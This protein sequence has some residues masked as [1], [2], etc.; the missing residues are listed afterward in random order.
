MTFRG[1]DETVAEEIAI[2]PGMEELFSLVRVAGWAAEGR[3]DT[4]VIDCAP[5]GDTIRMRVQ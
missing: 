5:T 2:L 1:V 3:F 4:I